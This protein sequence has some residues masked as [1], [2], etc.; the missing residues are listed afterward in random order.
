MRRDVSGKRILITGA[1]RGIGAATATELARR[2]ARLSLVGIEPGL[3]KENA[4]TL[5]DAH[6]WVEADVTDQAALNAAVAA[7]ADRFGGI[8]VVIAN[9]GVANYGTIRTADPDDFARTIGINLIG[10]YRTI[11]AAVPHLVD[12]RG[13]ALLVAS[14]ASF[15]PIP[16]A[17]SYGASKA[18]VDS[19]AAALRL[20]LKQY[21][22][23]VGSMHPS[24]IDTDLVRR[25]EADLPTFKKVRAQMPWP[26]NGTT[27]V[28]ECAKAM[29][30]AVE[31]RAPRTFVPKQAG[32]MAAIRALSFSPGLARLLAKR[33]AADLAQM[34]R[35][36]QALGATWR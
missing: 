1:A 6:M 28:E 26:A 20:E 35:E 9:A 7:T 10:V 13:Y 25:S 5:G 33:A 24:W 8:D 12:S 15:V 32:L 16:G 29:A 36:N 34:D 4:E 2:G 21:G 18:G 3:L 31:K 23:T 19:L 17:A 27:S 11:S 22:V 14:I 30:D